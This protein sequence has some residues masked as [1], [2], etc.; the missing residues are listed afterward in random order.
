MAES[1]PLKGKAAVTRT[2]PQ[3]KESLPQ[4][5]VR[6]YR[7]MKAR[8]IYPLVVGWE[9]S[10]GEHAALRAGLVALTI[11]PSIPGAL[12]M[13]MEQA[14]DPS[15]SDEG[16]TFQVM[17]LT[18]G[19]LPDAHLEVLQKDRRV[20]KLALPMR[21]VGSGWTRFLLLLTILVPIFLLWVK[22][23]PLDGAEPIRLHGSAE[24][25]RKMPLVGEEPDQK[26]APL[27]P[28]KL[29]EEIQKKQKEQQDA[30][31][32]GMAAPLQR[33]PQ[34]DV[35]HHG[36]GL[37][38]GQSGFLVKEALRDNLPD[39]KEVVDPIAENAGEAYQW[40]HDLSK[41]GGIPIAFSAFAVLLALTCISWMLH[42]SRRDKALGEP[43]LVSRPNAES[44][45]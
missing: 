27:D 16:V 17:P 14:V 6:Y 30:R 24:D 39:V 8:R 22:Y 33:P 11:R 36:E 9:K 7:R 21:S 10:G 4:L 31:K 32:G 3:N 35:V 20:Q 2:A 43:L 41:G 13:P 26:Q 15:R 37:R 12:V 42:G 40:V 28:K 38:R 1:V 5:S 45:S 19:R 23:N 44:T 29:F 25:N 34:K 18:N